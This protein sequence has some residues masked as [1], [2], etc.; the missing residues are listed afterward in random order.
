MLE[1]PETFDKANKAD[2]LAKEISKELDVPEST[3]LQ[4]IYKCR[5]LRKQEEI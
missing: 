3:T 2:E 1:H 4:Y 5:R